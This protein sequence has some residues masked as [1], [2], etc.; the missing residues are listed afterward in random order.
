LHAG[1][2]ES[3]DRIVEGVQVRDWPGESFTGDVA[4]VVVETFGCDTPEPY[5]AAMV[6][7]KP[8]PR[9]INLEYLSAEDWVEGSHA[10]PSPHPRLPLTKHY[11]FPGFTARTGGL[12]RERDL[13]ERRDR[14]QSDPAARSAL[15]KSLA[16]REPPKDALFASVF[17]YRGAPLHSLLEAWARGSRPVW[18]ALT[19]GRQEPSRGN[20]T[21]VPVEFLPQ[22]RY[23][24]LLWASDLNFVRGEDS[25]VRAQWAARPFVWHIYPQEQDAHWVKLSAFLARFTAG[26]D[27]A[28]AGAISALWEA[29]NRGGA[30]DM[31][32]P[33]AG[34]EPRLPMFRLLTQSWSAGLA[35]REDLAASLAKFTNKLL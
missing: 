21:A 15:W 16:G 35:T 1:V 20:L 3:G 4:D 14:F 33:W 30:V 26:L 32:S 28:D 7:R 25:F 27:R 10:L 24:E 8:P 6:A 11:F 31:A 22:E 17:A 9:W 13:L 12:L 5:V 19:E 18:C 2:G 34:I 23:D 29:W